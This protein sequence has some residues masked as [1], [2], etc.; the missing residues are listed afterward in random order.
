[1]PT[2]ANNQDP[3]K[4]GY[5]LLVQKVESAKSL[6]TS[7]LKSTSSS[8]SLIAVSSLKELDS[9]LAQLMLTIQDYKETLTMIVSRYNKDTGRQQ[10]VIEQLQSEVLLLE[11]ENL[12][13][14]DVIDQKL[15]ASSLKEALLKSLNQELPRQLASQRSM[16]L[17][18]ARCRSILDNAPVVVVSKA[19][20]PV[21]IQPNMAPQAQNAMENGT[22]AQGSHLKPPHADL[23]HSQPQGYS[24]TMNIVIKMQ[25]KSSHNNSCLSISE[26]NHPKFEQITSQHGAYGS[27][28][29]SSWA[30]QA[31][32]RPKSSM[33]SPRGLEKYR[34]G[35]ENFP[36]LPSSR[37]DEVNSQ[38]PT[39]PNSLLLL[40]DYSGRLAAHHGEHD[41]FVR[42]ADVHSPN[43]G[44]NLI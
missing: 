42:G 10:T 31:A 19:D 34:K 28:H 41:P 16:S 43:D 17:A 20:H 24:N 38:L 5:Q 6:I 39:K 21:P 22:T 15:P 3:F 12:F 36:D 32:L 44:C 29:S 18:S 33:V 37:F 4:E 13:L 25:D 2:Q 26:Q 35:A 40:Q 1:M 9:C 7:T 14:R 23:P 11:D 8:H 27:Y 30:P